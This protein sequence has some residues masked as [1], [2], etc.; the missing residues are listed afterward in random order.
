[1]KKGVLAFRE[2]NRKA[3]D[4]CVVWLKQEIDSGEPFGLEDVE[5]VDTV[6]HFCD[7]SSVLITMGVL[8][9][10]LLAMEE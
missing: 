4:L 5:K 1:M 6:L 10:M 2:P 9:D 7:R 3:V 8:Q